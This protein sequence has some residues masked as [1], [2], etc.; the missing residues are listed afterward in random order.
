[1]RTN[2]WATWGLP[3]AIILAIAAAFMSFVSLVG[4]VVLGGLALVFVFLAA[5]GQR[6]HVVA[7]HKLQKY[8]CPRCGYAPKVEELESAP[9]FPCPTCGRRCSCPWTT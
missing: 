5:I 3:T 7:Q 8:A 1:M 4:G 2:I 6:R 9:S